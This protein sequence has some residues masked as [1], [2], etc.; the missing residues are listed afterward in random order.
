[1]HSSAAEHA[2]AAV[3]ATG[4]GHR[5]DVRAHHDRRKR[6]VAAGAAPVDVADA[7]DGHG[8]AEGPHALDHVAAALAVGR[9]QGEAVHA[10]QAGA[11]VGVG[12]DLA[13]GL[14]RAEEAVAV[15]VPDE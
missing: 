6:V 4:G 15:D 10:P 7:V 13:E 9:G 12:A 3:E 8:Q 5:V 1:M 2:E 11:L 14:E